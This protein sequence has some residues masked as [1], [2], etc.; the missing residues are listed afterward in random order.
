MD[1][2][3]E[4]LSFEDSLKELESIISSIENPNTKLLDSVKLYERGV[5]LKNHSEKILND[6][7]L[8]VDKIQVNKNSQNA[9]SD[10]DY[11]IKPFDLNNS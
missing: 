1:D 4:K 7:K 6:A 5:A 8:I 11:T 9:T 10:M 3:L 2:N